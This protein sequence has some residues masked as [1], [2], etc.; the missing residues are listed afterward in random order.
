M[1]HSVHRCQACG[2]H[3]DVVHDAAGWMCPYTD[4]KHVNPILSTSEQNMTDLERSARLRKL[5]DNFTSEWN[6]N[7]AT[8]IKQVINDEAL[9]G[10]VAEALE[11]VDE[12]ADDMSRLL[13]VGGDS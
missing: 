2:R 11:F 10:C 8:F 3:S 4:C 1:E 13:H 6:A 5:A 12:L 7:Y 9:D